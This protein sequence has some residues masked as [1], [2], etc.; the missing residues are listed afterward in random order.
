MRKRKEKN[1]RLHHV[2]SIRILHKIAWHL[3][4]DVGVVDDLH[5]YESNFASEGR[6]VSIDEIKIDCEITPDPW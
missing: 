2:R 3:N 4:I 5:T 1:N 6:N